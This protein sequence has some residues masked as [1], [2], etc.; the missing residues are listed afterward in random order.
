[1]TRLN[2]KIM[3]ALNKPVNAYPS[4]S[5]TSSST[6]QSWS[7]HAATGRQSVNS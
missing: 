7:G 3:R 2:K 6:N 1:M 5:N 4:R